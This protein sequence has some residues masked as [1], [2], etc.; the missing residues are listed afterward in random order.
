MKYR[1]VKLITQH[2]LPVGDICALCKFQE[3]EWDKNVLLKIE[4]IETLSEKELPYL[5]AH[6]VL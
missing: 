5:W 4:Q 6:I 2:Q 3:N 1:H